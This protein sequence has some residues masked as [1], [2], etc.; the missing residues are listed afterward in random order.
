MNAPTPV[1]KLHATSACP[2]SCGVQCCDIAVCYH[3]GV[4]GI[5]SPSGWRVPVASPFSLE[6]TTRAFQR[7]PVN[8]VQVWREGTYFRS[9]RVEGQ[10][11][12]LRVT[13]PQERELEIA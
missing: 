7:L 4:N 11:L 2:C 9:L 3:E 1:R 13:Q 5:N 10:H 6:K 8:E 12:T